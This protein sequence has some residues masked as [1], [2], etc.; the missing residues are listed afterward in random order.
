[1]AALVVAAG[2]GGGDD[3]KKPPGAGGTGPASAASFRKEVGALCPPFYER[4]G[5]LQL[6]LR[7]QGIT[8]DSSPRETRKALET[9]DRIQK[10][11]QRF[12]A[13]QARVG[14]PAKGRARRDAKELVESTNS[15]IEA[16][17]Q[18]LDYI[19]RLARTGG[20]D[21]DRKKLLRIRQDLGARIQRQQQL[22]RRLKITKCLAPG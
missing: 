10:L 21:G 1:M 16:Q 14:L 9:V 18:N 7:Q 22:V 6:R 4:A 5:S 15:F 11:S 20:E 17:N 8:E 3:E 2:C 19:S 13:D 12:A